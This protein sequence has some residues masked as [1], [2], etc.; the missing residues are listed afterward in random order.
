MAGRLGSII[1]SWKQAEPVILNVLA[2]RVS[3]QEGAAYFT[4]LLLVT[5]GLDAI[6]SHGGSM[7]FY[8]YDFGRGAGASLVGRLCLARVALSSISAIRLLVAAWMCQDSLWATCHQ[9]L[10]G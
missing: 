2:G 8:C 6:L 9:V 7:G 3:F 4:K 10:A 5:D 1:P